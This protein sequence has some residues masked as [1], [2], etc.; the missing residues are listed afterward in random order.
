MK[1]IL[2][3]YSVDEESKKNELN[4]LFYD[5]RII[6]ND[7]NAYKQEAKFAIL[8]QEFVIFFLFSQ[9]MIWF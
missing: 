6:E 4:K 3:D 1:N 9:K 8:K 5:Y 7:R 2:N